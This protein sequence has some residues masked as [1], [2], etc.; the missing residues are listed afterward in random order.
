MDNINQRLLK[1]AEDLGVNIEFVEM[2]RSGIYLSKIKTIFLSQS[3]IGTN[4][5]SFS[6]SH[7]L[8]HNIKEHEKYKEY[9]Y[10]TTS[11]R[12]KMERE[13][14]QVA[15]EILLELY[16]HEYNIENEQLNPVLFMEKF[17]I[18]SHLENYVVDCMKKY[19]VET[20]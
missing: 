7:E 13:A 10:A 8:G 4:K 14:N 18:S 15:I 2:E 16:L 17:N 12:G 19:Y 6:L 11:S 3:I 9:Y 1:K 20:L 5:E